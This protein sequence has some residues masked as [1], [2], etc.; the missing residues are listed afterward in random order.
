[1]WLPKMHRFASLF[2]T[3]VPSGVANVLSWSFLIVVAVLIITG[4]VLTYVYYR[5][6]KKED[7]VQT[8]TAA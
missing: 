2:L 8:V 5:K 3:N 7:S 6:Y 4:A 1:M